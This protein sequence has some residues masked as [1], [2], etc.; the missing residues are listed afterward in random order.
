MLLSTLLASGLSGCSEKPSDPDRT[1]Y[2]ELR[3]VKKLVVG[4]MTLSKMATIDDIRLSEAR[5]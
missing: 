4:R 3:A 2:S 1:Y 5:V